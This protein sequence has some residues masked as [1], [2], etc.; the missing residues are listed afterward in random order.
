M[1]KRFWSIWL[2]IE[3]AFILLVSVASPVHASPIWEFE[4]QAGWAMS[5][6]GDVSELPVTS[7]ASLLARILIITV[8]I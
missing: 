2:V 5:P 3:L 4:S 6:N 8:I 1:Q 7:E